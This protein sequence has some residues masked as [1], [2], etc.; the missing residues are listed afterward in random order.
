MRVLTP[1]HAE[2]I[3]HRRLDPRPRTA[4]AALYW[5][6]GDKPNAIREYRGLLGLDLPDWT[7]GQRLMLRVASGGRLD[8]SAALVP[9]WD[10]LANRVVSQIEGVVSVELGVEE[11]PI[12]PRAA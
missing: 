1:A 11:P 4:L 7:H 3:A 9:P 12:P 5:K 10:E 8:S 6:R 2:E